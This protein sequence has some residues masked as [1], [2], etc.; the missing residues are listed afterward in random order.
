MYMI[1]VKWMRVVFRYVVGSGTRMYV[2][3]YELTSGFR[4][5]VVR[6]GVCCRPNVGCK[7]EHVWRESNLDITETIFC[8][9]Y[10]WYKVSK[11]KWVFYSL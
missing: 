9:I 2:E 3:L 4:V 8:I 7:V 11:N 5:N 1:S 10:S 6:A